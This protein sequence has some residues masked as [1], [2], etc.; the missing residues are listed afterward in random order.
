MH[1]IDLPT[2]CALIDANKL[3]N[4]CDKARTRCQAL[5]VQLRPHVKTHKCVDIALMQHGGSMGPITVSTLAEAAHFADHGFNDILYAVPFPITRMNDALAL[6]RRI[7]SLRLL[8]DHEDTV[9]ALSDAAV[10]NDQR[11]TVHL[12][13]DTGYHRAGVSPDAPASLAL[14]QRISS[15]PGLHFG[16]IVSHTGHAYDAQTETDR[17]DIAEADRAQ[18][19][20][21]ANVLRAQGVPVPCV[22]V[23]STP[24]FAVTRNL[25]GADEVRIGNYPFYDAFQAEIGA[26]TYDDIAFSVLVSVIGHYPDRN[27]MIIDIG[28]IGMSKDLGRQDMTPILGYG[29]LATVESNTPLSDIQLVGLSQEHGR[30][31][32]INK[33]IEFTQYPIGSKFR[34]MPNHSCLTAAAFDKYWLFRGKT[35]EKALNPCKFWS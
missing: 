33:P 27:L 8:V 25:Q 13:I 16:G 35:V 12:K 11:F 23:G 9:R 3:Q 31:V 24:A 22:S 7:S 4:N 10:A 14:A 1:I 32:G 28:S 6:N 30:I 2:P 20:H 34:V 19:V 26:C 29:R 17:A 5:D 15:S 21:F 18:M